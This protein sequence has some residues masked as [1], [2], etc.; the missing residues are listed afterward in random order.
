MPPGSCAP[1]SVV[2]PAWVPNRAP[3][4]RRRAAR[5]P[6]RQIEPEE[7]AAGG[8][9]FV[10]D[11]SAHRLGQPLDEREPEAGAFG[12]LGTRQTLERLEEL[13]SVLLGDTRPRVADTDTEAPSTAAERDHHL[14]P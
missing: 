3:R 8:H 5:H 7:A 9:C 14:S 11:P 4:V 12:A 10:A 13:R 2:S 6:P 1:A